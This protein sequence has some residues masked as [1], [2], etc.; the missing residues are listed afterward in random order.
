MYGHVS[1]TWPAQFQHRGVSITLL[2]LGGISFQAK[3]T[4][5]TKVC[6]CFVYSQRLHAW[7]LWKEG[8]E[9]SGGCWFAWG[10]NKLNVLFSP[11]VWFILKCF[12][13]S[14]ISS[15]RNFWK[16]KK[17]KCHPWSHH[18]YLS[19]FS[20]PSFYFLLLKNYDFPAFIN[21][22]PAFF[23]SYSH[24]KFPVSKTSSFAIAES[25]CLPPFGSSS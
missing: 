16:Y 15:F 17:K 7:V 13:H 20:F 3:L 8:G 6:R 25:R 5:T 11:R 10:I 14:K 23:T 22:S 21:L 24:G 12:P 1:A 19:I 4:D 18:L 9:G 2:K